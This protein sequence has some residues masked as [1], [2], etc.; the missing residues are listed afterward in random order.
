M[1][2][3]S[4]G[5]HSGRARGAVLI[6]DDQR[7]VLLSLQR[8]LE[9]H[10]FATV[11]VQTGA[12]AV[13]VLRSR[14][15]LSLALVDIV[16]EDMDAADLIGE[17][18]RKRPGLPVV[19]MSGWGTQLEGIF[20]GVEVEGYLAKPF[21]GAELVSMILRVLDGAAR[22]SADEAKRTAEPYDDRPSAGTESG[23]D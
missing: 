7:E 10:G 14:S 19:A 3:K 21:E 9:L 20:E 22:T 16:L 15:R 11:A 4:P 13:D 1:P 12:G 17:I 6:V 23:T 18:R 8:L 2:A 5:E